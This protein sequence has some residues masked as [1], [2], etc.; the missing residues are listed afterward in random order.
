MNHSSI[1]VRKSCVETIVEFHG[2]VGDDIYQFLEALRSDQL[3]LVR[4]YVARAIK[5]KASL[6]S[7]SSTPTFQL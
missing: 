5:K 1:H 4:H 2:V 7:L 3:N 6:N